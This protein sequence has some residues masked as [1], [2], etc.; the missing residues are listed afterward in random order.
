MLS[1]IRKL[2]IFDN[3]KKEIIENVELQKKIIESKLKEIIDSYNKTLIGDKKDKIEQLKNIDVSKEKKNFGDNIKKLEGDIELLEIDKKD[4]IQALNNI[5]ITI[6]ILKTPKELENQDKEFRNNED[7]I[8]YF[9]QYD[10]STFR[11]AGDEIRKD[12]VFISGFTK[13]NKDIIRYIDNDLKKDDKFIAT[14]ASEYPN[15]LEYTVDL[16]KN[17]TFIESLSI[18]KPEIFLFAANS[19]RSDKEYVKELV[20]SKPEI[21]KYIDEKLKSDSKFISALIQEVPAVF[22]FIDGVLKTYQYIANLI[23]N[24]KNKQIDIKEYKRNPDVASLVIKSKPELIERF[25]E[26]FLKNQGFILNNPTIFQYSGL[27]DDQNFVI[28]IVSKYPETIQYIG[29]KLKKTV[30]FLRNVAGTYPDT[31][32]YMPDE[33]KKDQKSIEELSKFTDVNKIL[34]YIDNDLKSDEIFFQELIKIDPVSY[35]YAND[36]LKND[37]KFIKDNIEVYPYI[38]DQLKEKEEILQVALMSGFNF[39]QDLPKEIIINK[40]GEYSGYLMLGRN[41]ELIKEYVDAYLN[42][43]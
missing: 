31:F 17:K 42:S 26:G 43:F 27:T 24:D 32:Q 23:V 15:I 1:S 30:L 34:P 41:K 25:D 19:L 33:F 20:S 7:M 36:K 12:K 16:S 8:K 40:F 6:K 10:V 4:K 18:K 2:P 21:L 5:N 39:N 37:I 3:Y 13:I 38:N 29:D 14:I 28:N 9:L 22:P 11:Y 35:K